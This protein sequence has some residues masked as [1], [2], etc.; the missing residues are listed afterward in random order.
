MLS[1]PE[2]W[3]CAVEATVLLFQL[4]SATAEECQALRL[5][6]PRSLAGAHI[7]ANMALGAITILLVQQMLP[8]HGTL[9]S[10][11]EATGLLSLYLN[12]AAEAS[13]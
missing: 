5:I 6:R 8:E 10:A 11:A 2:L 1:A 12:A 4:Q 3:L 9:V 13:L 7:A